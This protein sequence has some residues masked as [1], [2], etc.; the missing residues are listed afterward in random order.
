MRGSGIGFLDDPMQFVGVDRLDVHQPLRD[1]IQGRAAS[2]QNVPHLFD[3]LVDH[4]PHFFV[5]FAGRFLAVRPQPLVAAGDG[6]ERRPRALAIAHPAQAAHA[7]VHDHAAGDVGGAFQVVLGAGRDIVKH[8][9]FRDGAGQQHL[10]PALQF[11]LGHQEP[12]ALGALQRVAQGRH[13]ARDDGHL[14]HRVGVGQRAGDQRMS[15]FVVG[16]A[17]LFVVAHHALF[18]L[19][20]RRHA[21]HAFVELRHA[22]PRTAPCAR[23]AAR[24]R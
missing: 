19:Q 13:T 14:V 16:D 11:R 20:P 21:F 5:D 1:R 17:V 6:Q 22:R 12:V 15:G 10:D 18:L 23:P 7:E 24:L 3:R 4:P 9:F 8:H 2:F